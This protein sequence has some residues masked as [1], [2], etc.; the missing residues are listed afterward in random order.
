MCEIKAPESTMVCLIF[1]K[2]EQYNHG[3]WAWDDEGK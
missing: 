3:G 1:F 2:Q